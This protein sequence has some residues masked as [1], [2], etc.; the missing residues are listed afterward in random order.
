M[1][2]D[3]TTYLQ[4]GNRFCGIEHT[5]EN[6]QDKLYVTLLK[7]TKKEVDIE[8]SFNT[9]TIGALADKLPK[10]QH[11]V[12][13]INNEHVL[14]KKIE[15][16]VNND[17]KL[18]YKAFPNIKLDEFYYE[19]LIQ[20]S[21]H[22]VSICRKTDIETLINEYKNVGVYIIDISLGNTVVFSICEFINSKTILTSNAHIIIEDNS[23]IAIDKAVKII[24]TDYDVKGIKISNNWLLS[25]SGVLALILNNHYPYT[26]IEEYK[27]LLVNEYKQSHFFTQF[28]KLGLI[29]ILGLLLINFFFFNHY[30]NT[31]N[32]LQQISQINQ[33]T[34]NKV[35][36]L[37]QTVSKTQ[38]MVDDMLKSSSSKS[39]FYV[40]AIAES[41]PNTILLSELNYQP[42]LKRIKAE[43]PIEN[44]LNAILISGTSNSSES[45]SKWIADLESIDW[46]TK[47]EILSYADVSKSTSD[48]SIKLNLIDD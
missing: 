4:F 29:F 47:V 21:I 35:L 14:T 20:K 31:V 7:K 8:K 27:W 9:T 46:V 16:D 15:S 41:V 32:D 24:Q 40:N 5:S 48:F 39:S 1:L 11:A 25:F 22:F 30:F 38:K 43:Q 17:L 37:N 3:I 19:V 2:K 45:Y 34:K 6:G 10:N 12:L 42:L 18:V 26:N 44:N 23:I 28:L 13:I 36:E 33:T